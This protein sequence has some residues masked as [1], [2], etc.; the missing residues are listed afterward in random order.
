MLQYADFL[1]SFKI[2]FSK[3]FRRMVF[4]KILNFF[5]KL[6]M[7]E[8]IFSHVSGIYLATLLKTDQATYVFLGIC[9]NFQNIFI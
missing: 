7:I 2:S 5:T 9:K 6:S 8:A 1:F 4:L 3:L